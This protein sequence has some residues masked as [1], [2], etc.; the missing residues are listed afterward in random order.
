MTFLKDITWTEIFIFAH[1]CAA[2]GCVLRVLYKQ[3]NIG[4]TFAWLI[5]LFLFP[6]FG[7]IAYLLIGE[8]RLGTARAK[9][10]GEMNRF[11]QSFAE[12]YLSEIY[13]GVGDNVKSRYHGISRVAAKGTGLGA[14]RNNAMTLLSTTDEIIDTMLADIRA[15]RHSCMLAFYI[16]EPEGRIEELLNELLAAADRGLDCAI[17]A[18]A[19][20]SHRLFH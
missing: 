5:I 19:V 15:A 20:G 9:R 14:T 8:P 6:V 16:I 11:Y 13:L 3:K 10:T 17:L 1:T 18:D 12:S 4:S 7:T 2:L